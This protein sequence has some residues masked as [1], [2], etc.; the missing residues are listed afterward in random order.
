VAK[1]GLALS[2]CDL[3]FWLAAVFQGF[4]IATRHNDLLN[5][6]AVSSPGFTLIL[7]I[8]S[9]SFKGRDHENYYINVYTVHNRLSLSQID[10]S[11]IDQPFMGLGYV[12]GL[13]GS[14]LTVAEVQSSNGVFTASQFGFRALHIPQG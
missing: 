3:P 2:L 1:S 12:T 8:L 4:S 11:L 13:A 14:A 9:S 10:R 5:P 6:S 7:I